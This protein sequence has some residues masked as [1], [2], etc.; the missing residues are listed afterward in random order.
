MLVVPR[1]WQTVVGGSVATDLV[2]QVDGQKL[3]AEVASYLVAAS[4]DLM[5]AT[6]PSALQAPLHVETLSPVSW[7]VAR[8]NYMY[9]PP[10]D[11]AAMLACVEL[12]RNSE[13]IVILD[14]PHEDFKRRLLESLLRKRTPNTSSFHAFISW[15]NFSARLDQGWTRER[16]LLEFL[17][18]Y[19]RRMAGAGIGDSM[20]VA[21]PRDA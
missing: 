7:R 8:L 18:A 20:L 5:V 4:L 19:N 15:R 1:Y 11:D 9:L 3:R 17:A 14:G 21:I 6:W 12:A 2:A 16:T 13:L 10:N